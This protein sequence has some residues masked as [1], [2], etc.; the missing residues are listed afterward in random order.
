M[1]HTSLANL[2]NVVDEEKICREFLYTIG[3]LFLAPSQTLSDQAL[4]MYNCSHV[5]T[6]TKKRG[7]LA[8]E[9][10]S[11]RPLR[12]IRVGMEGPYTSASRRPT[13][14]LHSIASATAKFTGNIILHEK[15]AM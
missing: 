2:N 3:S 7:E 15:A 10:S 4:G 6:T 14:S 13:R 11:G 9:S 5:Q 1:L 8:P 12:F